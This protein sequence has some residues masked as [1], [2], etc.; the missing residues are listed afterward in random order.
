MR[1]DGGAE[2]RD[3]DGL[4]ADRCRLRLAF[5]GGV[6]MSGTYGSAANSV[7][8][9][10][11]TSRP[12]SRPYEYGRPLFVASTHFLGEHA[13]GQC[14][15][16][17]LIMVAIVGALLPDIS[18]CVVDTALTAD[19]PGEHDQHLCMLPDH[20]HARLVPVRGCG[21]HTKPAG[22][23]DVTSAECAGAEVSGHR[24]ATGRAK[25]VYRPRMRVP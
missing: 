9:G 23:T 14:R 7:P 18:T 4:S 20:F 25:A 6:P 1:R 8:A 3:N 16:A 5:G 22:V 15:L 11:G 10:T 21:E 13:R 19:V 2:A 17:N 12:A 24:V